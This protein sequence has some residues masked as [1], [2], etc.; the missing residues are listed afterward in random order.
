[1]RSLN[2]GR[3]GYVVALL[4]VFVALAGC[5]VPNGT[6]G[7]A[8]ADATLT[9]VA[10]PADA[11]TAT[12][13]SAGELAPG[14]T[15]AGVVDPTRLGRAHARSL[16]N[17][18]YTF[19]R[20]VTRRE[21]NGT[22]ILGTE[23]VLRR[24][25]AGDRF[26]YTLRFRGREQRVVDRYANGERVYE[27]VST[28]E[29]TTYSLFGEGDDTLD[30]RNASFGSLTGRRDV[31]DLFTRFRFEVQRRVERNGTT[32]YRLATTE[33]RDVPPLRDITVRALVSERGLVREYDVSYRVVRDSETVRI[34]VTV[35][36]SDVGTTRVAEP[37]WYD[38]ARRTANAMA[39]TAGR[40]R[41]P[42]RPSPALGSLALA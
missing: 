32:L 23:T 18:S 26:R 30:P 39:T 34:D 33:P 11:D 19:R 10:V 25:A 21:P 36:F 41:V 17:V 12:P 14:L 20:S 3:Q 37:G 35:R 5:N 1:M 6:G 40:R 13:G 7:G 42:G 38:A 15:A 28:A 16:Q 27:R 4:T 22:L 8:V 9:P 2:G 24:A 31:V 29:T